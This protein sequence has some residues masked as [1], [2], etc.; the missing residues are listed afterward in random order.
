MT[1][2]PPDDRGSRKRIGW[3]RTATLVASIVL[4]VYGTAIAWVS[5]RQESLLFHPIPLPREYSFAPPDV[6]EVSVDVDGATLSAL[7]FRLPNPKGVVFFL[8]GNSGN[9]A[10]WFTAS[11]FYRDANFDLFMVD[12]R[13]FGK[14]TGRIGSETELRGDVR[15]AWDAVAP[16]Y[17]G[18]RTVI[19]G[20]SLGTA[21][22]A[23]LAAEVQPDLT[24]LVSPY[25]SVADLARTHFPWVPAA[26]VRYPLA[27]YADVRRIRT[28]VLL[29]H[30]EDDRLIPIDDS[31]RLLTVAP[32]GELLRVP[33]A[34]HDDVH[35]FD[36]YLDSL[37]RHLSRL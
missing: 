21:L 19:Y 17:Q 34:H 35:Q 18:K 5:L 26:L 12:Y 22:A 14:S 30:G 15:K 4:A 7:H 23:G 37:A 27:T 29:V 16:M 28:P 32:Q 31:E 2:A 3:I 10:T 1:T 8:H 33:G 13:G 6:H 20:R 25:W 11:S 24:I 36:V 9:L